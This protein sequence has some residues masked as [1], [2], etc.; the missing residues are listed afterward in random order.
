MRETA[1]GMSMMKFAPKRLEA[2]ME[3]FAALHGNVRDL[4]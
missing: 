1:L 3:L 2:A 4:L